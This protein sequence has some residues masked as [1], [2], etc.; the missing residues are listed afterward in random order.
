MVMI[1]SDK[2]RCGQWLTIVGRLWYGTMMQGVMWGDWIVLLELECGFIV[3]GCGVGLL[4][5]RGVVGWC[6]LIVFG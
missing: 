1:R 4:F 2:G 6:V 5:W 3:L